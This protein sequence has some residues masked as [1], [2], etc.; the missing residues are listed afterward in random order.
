MFLRLGFF[1]DFIIG[2]KHVEVVVILVLFLHLLGGGLG[3]SGGATDQFGGVDAGGGESGGFGAEGRDV[4]VPTEGVDGG[5]GWAA[6][7]LENHH[8]GLK[9]GWIKKSKAR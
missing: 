5:V 7:S 1:V 9:K 3:G 4:A 6:K 2:S 8:I